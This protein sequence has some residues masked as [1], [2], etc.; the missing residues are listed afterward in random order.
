M[1][2]SL[3]GPLWM[4]HSWVVHGKNKESGHYSQLLGWLKKL[5]GLQRQHHCVPVVLSSVL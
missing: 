3:Q 5:P 4:S 2:K 1:G